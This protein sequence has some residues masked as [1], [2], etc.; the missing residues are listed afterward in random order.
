MKRYISAILV[1]CLLLQ[2][3]AGC[4]SYQEITLDELK[5][6]KGRKVVIINRDSNEIILNR[7]YIDKIEEDWKT[8]DSSIVINSSKLVQEND[9]S[10]IVKI[11]Y[12]I[13]YDDIKTIEIEGFDF[14]N[15][16]GLVGLIGLGIGIIAGV[17]IFVNKIIEKHTWIFPSRFKLS[18]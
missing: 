11:R 13:K 6:Y 16:L 5:N 8:N 15:T 4:F 9:A 18:N 14:L 7:K 2:L 1:P 17:I 3:L 10:K 12:D